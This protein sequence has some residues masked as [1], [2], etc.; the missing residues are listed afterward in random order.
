MTL[1]A[2]KK[3]AYALYVFDDVFHISW[4]NYP[5]PIRVVNA[6]AAS[7]SFQYEQRS[8]NRDGRELFASVGSFPEKLS[9]INSWNWEDK[10]RG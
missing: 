6:M 4:T 3:D 7:G 10:F 8:L 9:S 1:V 2:Y 5:E